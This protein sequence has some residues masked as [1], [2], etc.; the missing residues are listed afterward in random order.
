MRAD[1]HRDELH[2]REVRLLHEQ[3]SGLRLDL[4]VV[5]RSPGQVDHGSLS[6][7]EAL[8]GR[9]PF[10]AGP[11]LRDV[12]QPHGQVVL[13]RVAERQQADQQDIGLCPGRQAGRQ[14]GLDLR[15]RVG[16]WRAVEEAFLSPDDP[17]D[18][19]EARVA[20]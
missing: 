19:L 10:A 5:N 7:N 20:F 17:R 18:R 2:D 9:V 6:V 8:P 11:F 16:G 4:G 13:F 1:R 12:Q 15:H 3:Q 14:D